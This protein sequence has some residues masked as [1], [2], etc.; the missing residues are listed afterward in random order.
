MLSRN[1]DVNVWSWWYLWLLLWCVNGDL[2]AT[3][4]QANLDR[5]PCWCTNSLSFGFR[6][7][8]NYLWYVE[9]KSILYLGIVM[10]LYLWWLCYYLRITYQWK[11]GIYV[12]VG[13]CIEILWGLFIGNEWFIE[14]FVGVSIPRIIVTLTKDEGKG[15]IYVWGR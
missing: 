13:W 3:F 4:R 8:T 2:I 14:A 7:R 1:H 5:V 10:R 11:M 9:V 12:S 15:E 6:E